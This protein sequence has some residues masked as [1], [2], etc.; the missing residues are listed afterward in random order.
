MTAT[1]KSSQLKALA[2]QRKLDRLQ[3]H[4]CV[5]DFHGGAYDRH[6]HVSPWSISACNVDS[7][8]MVFLQDWSS[9]ESMSGPLDVPA[10]TIGHT[11]T[12]PSNRNL[13]KL[14]K[15]YFDKDIRDTYVT[16]VFVF[17]KPGRMSAPIPIRDLMYSAKKYAIPQIDIMKPRLVICLGGSTYNAI[18]RALTLRPVR[19][20]EAL[21]HPVRRGESVIFGVS[22]TGGLGIAN[23]RFGQDRGMAAV[24]LQWARLAQAH[25]D[26]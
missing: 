1:E 19:L 3:G 23:A 6:D 22:H 9:E 20:Q 16:N 2:Q 26:R 24:N 4:S 14:L 8:I 13:K 18:R 15:T 25:N 11:P 10:A 12:L 7:D 21:D 17:I 5:G